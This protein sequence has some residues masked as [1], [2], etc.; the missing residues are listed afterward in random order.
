MT[1]PAVRGRLLA[2]IAPFAMATLAGGCVYYNG[3]YN[4]KDAAKSGDERLRRGDEAGASEQF[5]LSA[6]RAET[7]LVRHPQSKWRT[8][9]LYLAGRGAAWGNACEI[10]IDRLDQF[11]AI[12]GA[13][14]EDRDR[15]RL[16]LATCETR[17]SRLPV[18]RARLD[19]LLDVS[20]TETARQARIWAARAALA[21]GDRD[22]VG[23]YLEGI[24]ISSLQ[25]ELLQVSLAAGE[26]ARAESLLVQ[27]AARGDYRADATRAIRELWGAGEWDAAERIVAGYD[28]ARVGD[29]SRASMHY[30]LGDL[31]LRAGRDSIAGQHLYVART[32]AGRDTILE[33]ESRARLALL[34]MSRFRT[35]SEFDTAFARQDSA[36]LRTAFSRRVAE[37][38]LLIKLLEAKPDPTGATIYL[39]AEVARDSLEAPLLAR[40]LFLRVAREFD[41]SMLAPNALFAAGV[42]EPDSAA[43]WTAKIASDYP[44]SS[45]AGWLAGKDP[46]ASPDF[47]AAPE[48]LRFQWGTV[49]RVW[50]DSVR[51]LRAPP[52]PLPPRP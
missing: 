26:Y 52:K 42:L 14:E 2:L 24:D 15:A 11:L 50:A 8:R 41:G 4:A 40:T 37:Q 35:V 43:I 9:A 7:V 39:A 49:T 31:S 36:V 20:D 29:A 48:L 6:Q 25:W 22:A 45:I 23:R 19:S 10:A 21:A 28:L 51:K 30:L 5:Q 44:G 27:R 34:G 13:E 33:R 18:A 32:L 38:F 47:A 3:I 16:A 17:A 12:K 1:S 46:A